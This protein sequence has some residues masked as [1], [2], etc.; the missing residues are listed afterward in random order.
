MVLSINDGIAAFDD[1]APD[2]VRLVLDLEFDLQIA[3][4]R[5]QLDLAG[6]TAGATSDLLDDR[7]LGGDRG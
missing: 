1:D 4:L 5:R 3:V 6:G 7:F 2:L